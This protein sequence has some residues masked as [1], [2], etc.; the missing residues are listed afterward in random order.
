M[1]TLAQFYGENRAGPDLDTSF[2]TASLSLQRYY[3]KS[4]PF[5]CKSTQLKNTHLLTVEQALA[6]Y[7]VLIT[8]LKQQHGA[9]ACPV[10]AFGGR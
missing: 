5:G 3:G 1:H 9:A 10:I 7:A 4:L 8:E 6:D 2:S